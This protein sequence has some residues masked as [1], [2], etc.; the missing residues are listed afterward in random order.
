[1]KLRPYQVESKKFIY[2]SWRDGKNK[3]MLMLPTGSGKTVLAHSIINDGLSRGYNVLFTCHRQILVEQTYGRFGGSVIMGRDKRYNPELNLQIGSVYTVKK[4]DVATPKII[5]CDEIHYGY[6]AD[7][8]QGLFE[9]WP[10]ARVIG[11]SATPVDNQGYLLGGFDS[12]FLKYQLCDL[13]KAGDLVPFK[14][15]SPVS[16]D[17]SLVSKI[18]GEYNQSELEEVV[19]REELLRTVV[20]GYNEFGEGRKFIAFATTVKHAKLLR[21]VLGEDVGYIDATTGSDERRVVL[22][23]VK[24]GLLRGVVNIDVL[25]AGFDMPELSC[26]IDAAPTM[27]WAKWMQRLGRGS[28]LLGVNYKESVANGKQDCIY[29]DFANNIDEHG[30]PTDRK[31]FSFKPAI[32]RVLDRKLGLTEDIEPS[33]EKENITI[34]KT[35]FLK[36]IGKLLD[37]YE[38][39][40]YRVEKDLQ[41]DVN[42]F[43]EKTNLFFYRQNSGVAQYGWA[44]K[45]EFKEFCAISGCRGDEVLKFI[46]FITRGKARFIRFTSKSGLADISCF[47]ESVYFG[48]ELKLP[49]GKLTEHQKITIPEQI[50]KKIL[51]FFAE[52]VID[53]YDILEFIESNIVRDNGSI[54]IKNDIYKLYDRQIEYYHRHRLETYDEYHSRIG[55]SNIYYGQEV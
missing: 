36:K 22:N 44:L 30:M 48:I 11:L 47:Y 43:L 5:I 19:I 41:A 31:E 50:S 54:V 29:L 14:I 16:V 1:M 13:V 42:K 45:K 9:R 4:R 21:D 52:S 27:V 40:V 12:Y 26:I 35:V 25:T 55:R 20:K 37:K 49:Q 17:L 51:I 33:I 23:G 8:I 3:C 10:S 53:I 46:N 6:K 38:D 24:S 18:A 7:I 2:D 32:S 15:Y 34:E 28:R 39:K